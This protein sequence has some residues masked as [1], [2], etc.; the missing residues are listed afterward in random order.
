MRLTTDDNL[1]GTDNSHKI[2]IDKD[3][4]HNFNH[5]SFSNNIK[6]DSFLQLES[7]EIEQRPLTDRR[8]KK[9][10]EN[11]KNIIKTTRN[12]I[13]IPPLKLRQQNSFK[14]EGSTISRKDYNFL[15]EREIILKLKNKTNN[16]CKQDHS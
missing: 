5:S 16:I 8:L 7:S 4:N 14:K 11:N 3:K 1:L 9:A 15:N 10:Q 13:I 12:K 6:L 2:L